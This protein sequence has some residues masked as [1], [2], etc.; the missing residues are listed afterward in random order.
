MACVG[1]KN[2][3]SSHSRAPCSFLAKGGGNSFVRMATPSSLSEDGGRLPLG[4]ERKKAKGVAVRSVAP[5][6]D[7]DAEGDHAVSSSASASGGELVVRD[8]PAD[9]ECPDA[10]LAP[11]LQ[12]WAT[13]LLEGAL[14]GDRSYQTE[15]DK[16]LD[17]H[18]QQCE[19]RRGRSVA[20]LTAHASH[21]ATARRGSL[22]SP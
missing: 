22:D 10:Y 14:H 2:F 18:S 4:L 17:K 11:R 16:K 8:P 9:H 6:D 20:V 12:R 13:P 7:R 15:L 5:L 21:S 19:P 3:C 1:Q